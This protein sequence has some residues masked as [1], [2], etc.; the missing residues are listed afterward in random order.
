MSTLLDFYQRESIVG[1]AY[2]FAEEA[3]RGTLRASGEP[4]FTHCVQVAETVREWNLDDTS[5]AAA[6][7]HD[8]VE[9]T[10]YTQK[11]IESR[12]GPE[13]AS[14]VEGLTKLKRLAYPEREQKVEN[15]RRFVI[16]FCRDLRILIV[17]LA[18]RLHNMRTL[19]SLGVE[20]QKRI[21]WE[22]LEIY[23]PLAY[24]LGMQ[25]LSGELDD[26]AFPYV[27]P[28]EYRWLV[29]AVKD[30]YENR[31]RYV[32]KLV[33][34]V[35]RALTEHHITPVHID[36]R[37]KRYYSLYRKLQR[38]DMDLEKIYDLVA[39]R[40]IVPDVETCYA[41]L[42][43]IH[44]LWSPLPNR[45][46][47]YIAR[48]KPNGYRSLHT[49]VFC[50]DHKITE[51]QIRTREMH[52]EAELGIAAHWG[53]QQIKSTKHHAD[54]KGVQSRHELLWVEQLRNWQKTFTNHA[55]F[56]DSVK[57]DFF[58][59][60]I[61]V[62]TP[63]N[64]VI[65]LP[66]GSTPV[67]FAYRIHSDIGDACV[68]AKVNGKIAQLEDELHSGDIVEILTRRGKKPSEGW[69][70]FLKTEL[71]RRHVR[72]ALR[73]S[74]RKLKEKL[75]PKETE[76]KI[77]NLDRP[78]F[79]KDVTAIFAKQKINITYLQSQTDHRSVFSLVT[80]RCPSLPEEKIEKTLVQLKRIDGTKEVSYKTNR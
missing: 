25:R 61:F 26:L 5:V 73:G 46:K 38:S 75:V 60:R 28:E 62:V 64:D 55:E 17:K 35:E 79:L 45:F 16:S 72:S 15:L 23:A 22:T 33:P 42:G 24:R 78:G 58:K 51:F 41:T 52:D 68:G 6:L 76:F 56:V 80:V 31:L 10:E 66:I 37:A 63:Q 59:D 13:V 12:F 77:T 14:L 3:H 44:G 47:D 27:Y 19:A 54:W 8:V 30:P 18:D 4:Y 70:A 20:D 1:Q 40:V 39:L 34:I 9:D 71:A 48:P 43:A 32:Q 7:L 21:A 65:D 74:D 29:G 67:D 49:T 57:T 36:A 53:Y 2:A 11:D 69:L 50:V